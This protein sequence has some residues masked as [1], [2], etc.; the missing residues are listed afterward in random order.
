MPFEWNNFIVVTKDELVPNWYNSASTLYDLIQRYR[1]KPCGIKRVQLGGNG[2]IMLIDFDTL[3]AYIQHC[4]GDPRQAGHSLDKYYKTDKEA[5]RFFQTFQFDSG[6]Y[7]DL[8]YQNKYITNPNVLNALIGYRKEAEKLKKQKG[9]IDEILRQQAISFQKT[10]QVKHKANHT[11][12]ESLKRFKEVL[13]AFESKGYRSL[14]SGKHGNDNSRKVT[15]QTIALLE[16]MFAKDNTKPSPTEVYK[17]YAQFIDGNLDVINNETGECYLPAD[18]KLLSDGTVKAYLNVWQSKIATHMLRSGDRQRYMQA[19]KTGHALDKPKYAG[20]LLSI[21]D[22]QPPYK[23]PDGNRIWAYMGI[24]LGSE[25]ITC[26]VFGK[27]KEGIIRNFYQQLVRNYH[28]WGYNLPDGLEA[29]SSLNSSFTDTFLREGSM[30][31]NVRIEANNA[32]GKRIERYFRDL[33]YSHEKKR[34]EWI[35]RPF[36]QN[37]S[38]QQGSNGVATLY[39]DEIVNNCLED[40]INWN[41]TPHS[42]YSDLTR[43]QV[44]EQKQ[45]PGL[46]P[47]NYNGILPY[48]GHKTQTSCN[49]GIINLNYSKFL[50]AENGKV[51]TGE[52]LIKLYEKVEGKQISVCW[53]D[54]I[55][56]EPFKALVFIGN[57]LICEALPQPTY[58]R[59][60]IERTPQCEINRTIMSSYV[61]TIQAY[62]RRRK[63]SIEGVT[64]IDNTPKKAK[65]FELPGS[66]RNVFVESG[67]VEVLPE[68][69]DEFD[70]ISEPIYQ[71]TLKDTF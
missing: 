41:E 32:R 58:A 66:K 49:T 20:S 23:M 4:L 27:T 55:N 45:H 71:P 59:A 22:R 6:G 47:T 11:L 46:K 40:I 16:S 37:E 67:S 62:G 12:P 38:N 19:F 30:F 52:R 3:P 51:C 1:N 44:F 5:V 9:G 64:K 10:L 53:L 14:I 8:Q 43:W 34:P 25:A 15:E 42:V 13:K 61:E 7:L 65:T 70:M 18:F 17:Q 2:R 26:W 48:L 35:G 68:P 60:V 31:Q 39:Y 28:H 57:L 29:E 63:N 56:G 36:A 54:D 24:D 33:R 50:L 69:A 21:D